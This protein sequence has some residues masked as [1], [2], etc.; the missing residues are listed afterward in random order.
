M[1][2]D[3][4]RRCTDANFNV[5]VLTFFNG[6][7][8]DVLGVYDDEDSALNSAMHLIVERVEDCEDLIETDGERAVSLAKAAGDRDTAFE[9]I[10]YF[11]HNSSSDIYIT[12]WAVKTTST[13][14][15]VMERSVDDGE[16]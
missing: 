13:T 11:N 1:P 8:Y 2:I 6:E 4:N 12:P 7:D 14:V 16:G 5:C 10:D 15:D 3:F 9:A